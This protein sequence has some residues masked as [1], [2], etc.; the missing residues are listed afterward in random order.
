M[1]D[2]RFAVVGG[3]IIGVAVARR[4]SQVDPAARVTL[5]EKEPELGRHQTGHN[6]GVVHAGIYYAPGSLKARLCRQG[7][8]MLRTL[9]DEHGVPVVECGKVVVAGGEDELGRLA[10]IEARA[11]ANGVP[12]L[13]R[14]SA[15]ELREVE[16]RVQGVAALHSPHTAVVDYRAVT[17]ALAAEA[18]QRGVVFRLGSAVTGIVPHGPE[19]L[20]STGGQ[21][22]AVDQVV[23]CAGLQVDR[24]S[25]LAGDATDPRIVPFRGE[26]HLLR[27]ERRSLVNGLVYPVPDP[28]YPFLGVHL[29]RRVDGEVMVG[30]NAV[31]AL[32]REGYRWRDV[33]ARDLW[34]AT[35]WPGFLTFARRHWRTGLA[36][37]RGSLSR[38]AFVESAR[39]YL[40]ELTADDLVPGPSGVRAQALDRDGSLVDDFRLTR[41]GRVV[42]VRNAPSPAATSSLAIA[43]HVVSTVLG[44]DTDV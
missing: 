22:Q 12:G 14:L 35:A 7:A 19:V 18:E 33:S 43:E 34:Q 23:V 26:Y 5:F 28:R 37:L 39:R 44:D 42:S 36:E 1:A 20:I 16:P 24:V 3:G 41:R 27:P 6:S 10:D 2:S 4:L 17:R 32:A 29:T 11:R 13:R 31:L 8:T 25:A 21:E 9:C 30:P 40:P 38:R 15:A